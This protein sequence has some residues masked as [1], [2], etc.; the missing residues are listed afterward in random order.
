MDIAYSGNSC[1]PGVLSNFYL[2][3]LPELTA[4]ER[5]FLES[6]SVQGPTFDVAFVECANESRTTI[7]QSLQEKGILIQAD[8][9]LQFRK[10]F[11]CRF[12]LS[13]N[14]S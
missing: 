2:S 12:S 4:A 11:T 5:Y 9:Q 14:R 1:T 6:A 13:P 8:G 3:Q 10:P 7:V